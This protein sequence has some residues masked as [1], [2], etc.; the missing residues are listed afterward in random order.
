MQPTRKTVWLAA[1]A[2]ALALATP[3][4]QAQ[5]KIA[6]DCPP[7]PQRCGSYVYAHALAEHLKA[8]GVN[9]RELPVN[10]I[11]GEAERLDQTSQ[12]L[13]EVNMADLARAGQ[14][15]KLIFGFFAP[16]LFDSVEHLDKVIRTSDLMQR[17]NAGTT[18]KGVRVV[19]LVLVG[20]ATGIFN[21]K[22]P[23]TRPEDMA[24]LRIRA[25]DQN[26]MALF[27]AWGTNGVVITMPEV[28]NA[29]QTGIAD[30]YINPPFVPFLFGHT[31]IIKHYTDAK[32]SMP[33]RVAMV[34]EDWYKKLSE[35]DRKT[36]DEGVVKA[37]AANRAWVG[38]SDK[39]ALEQ[40]EKAGIK[41]TQLTPEGRARF[42]ELSQPAYTAI[43]SKGE[44]QLYLDAA[45]KTR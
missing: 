41:I 42:K 24:D 40:L 5:V 36:F 15:D 28:A 18:K 7:D 38:N 22:K 35:K 11:G 31:S 1:A 16:Y 19:S 32:V 43:L 29:L 14:L 25:L 45:S 8:A 27:K 39:T 12:G 23:I 4:A 33:L 21:T 13:L 30:G 10:S 20:G 6:L 34:S 26:Q 3:A 2:L 9:V 17:I 37:T 44:I